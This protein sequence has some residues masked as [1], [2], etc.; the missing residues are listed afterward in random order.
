MQNTSDLRKAP[1]I[2]IDI[3]R[4]RLRH[5]SLS[6]SDQRALLRN[7]DFLKLQTRNEQ[8]IFMRDYC[9]LE[10]HTLLNNK[11]LGEIFGTSHG[12]ISNIRKKAKNIKKELG[13][14]KIFDDDEEGQ[15][16]KYIFDMAD[17]NKFVTKQELLHYIREQFHQEVTK[18]W[19]SGFFGRNVSQ[20]GF[21]KAIP[22]DNTRLSVPRIFL[23]EHIENI[24]KYVVGKAAELVFNI[25]EMGSSEWEDKKIKT[26][27]APRNLCQKPVMVP[28]KRSVRH[29]TLLACISAAGDAI[30]PM[31]V[32]T[33]PQAKQIFRTGVREDIDLK[34][35]ISNSPYVTKEIF[36]EYITKVFLPYVSSQRSIDGF[37]NEFAVLLMD[38]HSTHCDPEILEILAK[39]RVIVITF[40]P[41]TSNIFQMLDLVI[42]GALKNVKKG[43]TPKETLNEVAALTE[44]IFR[45]YEQVTTST[46]V[47]ASFER[48]GIMSELDDDL[49]RI[50]FNEEKVRNSFEF[51]E[52]WNINFDESNLSQKRKNTKWGFINKEYFPEG[53]FE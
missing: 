13:R 25:D 26:V 43:L 30:V 5:T 12:V 6:L 14:P 15:I 42:F 50:I 11:R 38:N 28:V 21:T 24:K 51:L 10:C 32:A 53:S 9:E 49:R 45:A 33:S 22:Q 31:V 20:I 44:K 27:I 35:S 16:L 52:I 46:N 2:S 4:E 37:S 41:H 34:I 48:A 8:V 19:L 7:P 3:L 47:R 29:Q 17:K 40:P 18:G 1:A 36:Y 23:D 39:N